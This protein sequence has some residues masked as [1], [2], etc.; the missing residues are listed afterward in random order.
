MR[1]KRLV[2]AVLVAILGA[3]AIVLRQLDFPILPQAPFLKVD[4]SD[5]AVLLGLLTRGPAGALAVA[6]IR[7]GVH[8]MMKG[9][10]AGL[11]IGAMMSLFASTVFFIPTH[12]V[13]KH[14]SRSFSVKKWLL[15]GIIAT[16]LFSS[17]LGLFNYTIAL[18][19]Y[20]KVLN[21][22]IPSIAD[23]VWAIIVPFNV[24]KG[25]ILT[26]AQALWMKVITPHVVK[27]ELLF[28]DY[29]RMN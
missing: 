2:T 8:Y 1:N 3:W 25:V 22:P 16:F 14:T 26:I 7:D 28:H 9:G 13:L 23:Y 11:P 17:V 29:Q 12:W 24:I 21:F 10:E 19:L 18:P 6:S 5:L 4:F 15:T 27:R 20:V